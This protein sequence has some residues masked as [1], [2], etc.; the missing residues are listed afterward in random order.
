MALAVYKDYVQETT[1]T[2][3][4]GNITLAGAS[5]GYQS[6]AT[7]FGQNVNVYYSI[8]SGTL[9]EVGYGQYTYGTTVLARVAAQVLAGSSGSGALITLSGTSTVNCVQPAE[10]LADIGITSAFSNHSVPQ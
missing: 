3:G 1:A 2:T 5:S 8:V 10:T 7:A 4:T 9:W 6:F